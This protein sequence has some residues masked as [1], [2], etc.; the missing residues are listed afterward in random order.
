MFFDFA[1]F[2][3]KNCS[4]YRWIAICDRVVGLKWVILASCYDIP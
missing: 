1:G 4:V 3:K 2:F